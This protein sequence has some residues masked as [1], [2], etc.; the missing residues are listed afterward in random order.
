MCEHE[1]DETEKGP[2]GRASPERPDASGPLCVARLTGAS[3]SMSEQGPA[4]R[5]GKGA[6]PESDSGFG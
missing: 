1:N 2:S 3:S 5:R 4:A 6:K